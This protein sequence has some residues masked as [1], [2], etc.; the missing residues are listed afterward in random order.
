MRDRRINNLCFYFKP[1]EGGI[2]QLNRNVLE[3]ELRAFDRQRLMVL[4]VIA[5][6]EKV[7]YNKLKSRAVD[8]L[9]R[10]GVQQHKLYLSYYFATYDPANENIPVMLN[11][12]RNGFLHNQFPVMSNNQFQ[13][14][15]NEWETI[16]GT[17]LP[18]AS[19]STVGYGIIDKIAKL[20]I[21]QYK[22]M[23]DNLN[24]SLYE[25]SSN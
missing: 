21:D 14:L 1:N 22:Q 18:S 23:N 20:A 15:P 5:E 24:Q 12:I 17:Y 9:C 19:G 3:N 25:S 2:I 16:N 6:F 10:D 8:L 7:L 11:A 13:L 4:E